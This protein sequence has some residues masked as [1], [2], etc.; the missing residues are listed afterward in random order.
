MSWNVPQ[1]AITRTQMLQMMQRLLRPSASLASLEDLLNTF[2]GAQGALTRA[3]PVYDPL[4][5]LNSLFY[6]S[7]E[8]FQPQ[9]RERLEL[10][11]EALAE[12]TGGSTSA[13]RRIRLTQT[14]RPQ[15]EMMPSSGV[16]H[17]FAPIPREIPG[18]QSVTLVDASPAPAVER[19]LLIAGWLYAYPVTVLPDRAITE[20]RLEFDIVQRVPHAFAQPPPHVATPGGHSAELEAAVMGWLGRAQLLP[21][22]GDGSPRACVDA[23]VDAMEAEFEFAILNDHPTLSSAV[24]LPTRRYGDIGALSEFLVTALRVRGLHAGMVSAHEL[25]PPGAS[26][27]AQKYPGGRGYDHGY[28]AWAHAAS[29]ESGVVDLHYLRRWSFAATEENTPDPELREELS[30]LGALGRTWMRQAAYP[31]DLVIGGRPPTSVFETPD[32][33]E[34]TP[35]YTAV[36]TQMEVC[37]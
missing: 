4:E 26:P 27:R 36:E 10:E 9:E 1:G 19:A 31:L 28:V 17:L 35:I 12:G 7:P 18:L 29:G 23:T 24:E 11:R 32:T 14:L 13:S 3:V 8:V 2:D 15:R 20:L 34:M 6:E 30:S 21:L 22:T 33:G 16:L 37:P 25:L 5:V